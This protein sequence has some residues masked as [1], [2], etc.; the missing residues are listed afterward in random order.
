MRPHTFNINKTIVENTNW[1]FFSELSN[2]LNALFSF[3]KL[4]EE[5]ADLIPFI[6]ERYKI[7]RQ[8]CNK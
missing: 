2:R 1:K 6:E 8:F 4:I 5:N 3:L 7:Y